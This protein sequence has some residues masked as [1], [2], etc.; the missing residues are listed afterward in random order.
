MERWLSC[1]SSP[2]ARALLN[3][4]HSPF[5]AEWSNPTPG[6]HRLLAVATDNAGLSR[7]SS[8]INL[9]VTQGEQRSLTLISTGAVWSYF[10]L[11]QDLGSAWTTRDYDQA[12]WKSGPAQL[13]YG[14]GDEATEVGFGGQPAN[15][16]I[17]TYF[18]RAFQVTNAAAISKLSVSVLRDDG[19]VVYLNGQEVFRTGML[20][21]GD[22]RYNTLAAIT[23][24]GA[25]E[26]SVFYSK[27]LDPNLLEEGLN[28]LAVEV[29]QVRGDSSDISFDL[30]LRA[31]QSLYAP[32]ITRHPVG[33]T[34]N[35]GAQVRLEVA[36]VG[37][38]PLSYRWRHDGSFLTGATAP[39]LLL[40]NLQ[41]TDAGDYVVVVSNS[42]G[43]ATS[44]PASLI[45]LSSDS[46]GD[47]LPNDWEIRYGLNPT[48]N[49]ADLDKDGDGLSNL[50]REPAGFKEISRGVERSDTP[51]LSAPYSTAP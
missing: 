30:G 42:V 28:L 6:R 16:F 37:S 5:T 32:F 14:D 12:T 39:L 24:T 10:D 31:E 44:S 41:L 4:R 19:A 20:E 43:T 45:V 1:D 46:D 33:T 18:R 25:D 50:R 11:G 7:T 35:S 47:G 49:D 51:G 21:A 26:T 17:T 22:I 8:P 29:H 23:V 13:G 34:T 2:T 36:A 48:L 40:D 15:R 27:D 38:E 9:V 3:H